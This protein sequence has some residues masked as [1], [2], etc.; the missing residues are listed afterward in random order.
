MAIQRCFCGS[1]ISFDKCCRPLVLG[2]QK[3]PTAE[4]LMRSR[5]V[6]YVVQNADYLIATTAPSH[7]GYYAKE[8]ILSW[9]TQ[10]QWQRL[11]ISSVTPTTVE[12][13]AYYLDS[14]NQLQ[15]HHEHSRFVFENGEWFY[16]DGDYFEE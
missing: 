6:A 14:N 9:A 15:V 13:K 5:Y 4:A 16:V 1:A 11:E 12:F 3:A 7:R 8:D 10:N 2:L